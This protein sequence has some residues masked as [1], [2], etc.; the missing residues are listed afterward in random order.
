MST[1]LLLSRER[2]GVGIGGDARCDSP[3]HSAK[4][5]TY[6][7]MDMENSKIIHTELVQVR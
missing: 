2:G 7:V 4:Y 5:G 6:S 1:M 3:G